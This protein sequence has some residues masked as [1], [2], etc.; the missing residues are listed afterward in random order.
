MTRITGVLAAA[1]LVI[2]IAPASRADEPKPIEIGPGSGEL[3]Y[4]TTLVLKNGTDAPVTFN[5]IANTCVPDAPASF[6]V[7]PGETWSASVTQK[8]SDDGLDNCYLT[9]HSIVYEDAANA[10]NTFGV[11]Q[12]GS[13]DDVACLDIKIFVI[14]PVGQA[15]C[16]VTQGSLSGPKSF[17]YFNPGSQTPQVRT[18][19]PGDM[20]SC[21][22][23]GGRGILF[24]FYISKPEPFTVTAVNGNPTIAMD[25]VL[26]DLTAEADGNACVTETANILAGAQ[27]AMTLGGSCGKFYRIADRTNV[28]L[29]CQTPMHQQQGG[30]SVGATSQWQ[31][32]AEGSTYTMPGD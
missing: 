27:A 26:T 31:N 17:M 9:H 5:R 15:I 28:Q 12:Y 8:H 16:P 30:A 2:G 23:G 11:Q 18:T 29:T 20:T 32:I 14:V 13:S 7:G 3:S 10:G 19:C 4:S 21:R 6:T 25:C 24:G 22:G 1:L